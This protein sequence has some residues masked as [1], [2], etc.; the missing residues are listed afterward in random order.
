MAA[1]NPVS[2]RRAGAVAVVTI[3]NPPVNAMSHAA[4]TGLIEAM[5]AV[6]SDPSVEA[7]VITGGGACFVAGA[8]I[9]EMSQPPREPL[10]TEVVETIDAID[11]PLVAAL[12]GATL[13]GGLEIALACDLRIASPRAALGLPETRLGLVPGAGGTQRLPRLTGLA[14]A[15][16]LIASARIVKAD[17]ALALGIVDRVEDDV[18]AAA[19]AAAPAAVRRR[20]SSLP[21]PP[22]SADAPQPAT[23]AK[24]RPPSPAVLEAERLVTLAATVPFREGLAEEKRTF[25]ALRESPEAR[26]LRHVFLA[27][28]AA[29]RVPGVDRDAARPVSRVGV[30]GAGTMG[31]A[32]AAA[33][34]DA[35]YSVTLVERDAE[36]AA[37]GA[38]RV[39]DIYARQVAG[40]R[41]AQAAADER[42][43][44][45]APGHDWSALG[46]ADLIVEAAFEKMEVKTD[47]FSRLDGIAKAGAV[48][49]SNTSYLDLD[50]IAAAT[51]RPADVVG[52]HF[53]APANVM[54]LLEIVRGARTA[55]DVLSTALAVARKLGKQPVVAGNAHGFIGNRI[56]ST[57]RRHA[58]YLMEDGASPY[59][60]DA[61][62]V[63]FGFPMGV[64]AVS[65][66]SGLDIS[67]AMRRSQDATR[68]PRERY[69]AIADRLVEGG[70]LGR[71]TGAGY[72]SYAGG[73]PAPDSVTLEI[74]DRE[75]A[76]KGIKPRSFSQD[77]IQRRLLAAM[78]NEGAWLLE[79]GI[80]MRGSDI[81]LVLINGYGFPRA[82]G[83]PMFS[84]DEIGL[85]A[86][87]DEI[88]AAASEN[89]GSVHPAGLL[90]SSAVE[91]GKLSLWEG[92]QSSA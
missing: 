1:D 60:I 39:A 24:G 62:L 19:I 28:R 87:R 63:A 4:R 3:D 35:G 85:A 26:A 32:I 73:K 47:I 54:K 31:A 58:E 69:V 29:E 5:R 65:D 51:A 78:A 92:K 18:V 80:A 43:G 11:K 57:Y 48:L 89:P 22:A 66:L 68:D 61:A 33:F 64:F 84:A 9:K 13:G 81:D 12:N 37:A 40:G 38:A 20:L 52:L 16:D 49:A 46:D 44:R 23:Q 30:V 34:A 50:Q 77:H 90:R 74:I 53:F 56:F 70:R 76:A 6:G 59:D 83:G 8:D 21:V 17:E 71:K 42:R 91:G 79:Q 82:K 45:I 86:I 25:F 27:E 2:V 72:Y 67:Y 7:I 55:P 15:R 75:R 10:L 88:E 41:L 36:A 14:T